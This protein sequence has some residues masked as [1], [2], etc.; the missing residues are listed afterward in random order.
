MPAFAVRHILPR[1][2]A[3][4]LWGDRQRWGLTIDPDDPCWKEW[5]ET[6][7]DFYTANQ[8]EG[9]GTAVNDAGYRVMSGLDMTGKTVLEVGA[10]D[11]R[12]IVYWQGKPKE[13]ILADVHQGMMQKAQ[14]RLEENAVPYRA[15]L[16]EREQPL[17]LKDASVDAIVT[18]YSLEHLYPLRPYLEELHRVLKPGG[19]LIG[20]IPAEGG[21]AWG[22]GRFVT[23]RRW[24]KKH[25]TIDPDKIIC[26]EHPNFADEIIAE[27]DRIFKRQRNVFWPLPWL[28][29]LDVN[30]IIRLI[31]RKAGE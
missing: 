10:G 6:Y 19:T 13:Y 28:P 7:G 3:I 11:I 5:Q 17:P 15:V 26:W 9:V 18:F 25:T 22:A 16:L 21:L 23:S 2:I 20:A 31:Y 1:T 30:L 14:A 12:H 24:L 29:A 27:L 8:R 4:P